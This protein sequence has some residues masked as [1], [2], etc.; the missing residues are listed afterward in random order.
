MDS[1]AS[2]DTRGAPVACFTRPF[3]VLKVLF[4]TLPSLRWFYDEMAGGL[5]G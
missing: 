2:N 3:R 4:S 1:L 5:V